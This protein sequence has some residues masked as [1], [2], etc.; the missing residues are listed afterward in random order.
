MAQY[1]GIVEILCC[2]DSIMIH[3]RIRRYPLVDF[4]LLGAFKTPRGNL[5][6]FQYLLDPQKCST[7][8]KI[9]NSI[10]IKKLV[11]PT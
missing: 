9:I 8:Q 3:H 2:F 4:Y 10:T 5:A 6:R 11:D 7:P 1:L